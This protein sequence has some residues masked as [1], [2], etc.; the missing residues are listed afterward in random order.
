[1]SSV[2]SY[3]D[4]APTEEIREG[5]VAWRAY[6]WATVAVL[7]AVV[8]RGLLEPF[9]GAKSPA[10]TLFPAVA[11]VAWRF[12][13]GPSLFALVVGLV[14]VCF[15]F[16]EPRFSL[17]VE[18]PEY[19][20]SVVLFF[21][22]NL[23][24][25]GMFDALQRAKRQA[26]EEVV[27]RR[28][29]ERNLA[30]QE[31]LLRVTLASIGDAV[32]STDLH[33]KVSYMNSLAED[34]TGW[35]L[36]DVTNQT[37]DQVVRMV[38]EA[39]CV[40]IDNLAS[41]VLAE[42]SSVAARNH[43]LLISKDGNSIPISYVATPITRESGD[44]IG[45]ALVIR[46]VTAQRKAAHEKEQALATLNGLVASA[47]V[48][49]AILDSEMRYQ[50]VNGVLAKI[51]GRTLE[52][53]LG[54]KVADVIPALYP[55]AAA[56][57]ER[58][59]ET[60][61][62]IPEAILEGATATG[63]G[64]KRVFRE[65]WFPIARPENKVSAVGVIVQEITEQR[66]AEQELAAL[67]QRHTSL[68]DNAPLAVIEWD[69]DFQVTRWAGLAEKMFGWNAEEVLGR[70]IEEF[71]FVHADDELTVNETLAKLRDPTNK[72]VICHNRNNSK[73]GAIVDCEWYNSVV[74]DDSGK[75]I[76]VLSLVLDVTDRKRVEREL[77]RAEERFRASQEASLFGFTI[78]NSVRD[79]ADRIVDFQWEYV[80][81][82][83]ATI[84]RVSAADLVGQRLLEILPNNVMNS[85][86]F[87]RYVS[88]VE[89][90]L[91][92]DYEL[93][94]EGEGIDGWFRNMAVKLG[95]GVAV[96]F[97]DVTESRRHREQLT[98]SEARFRQLAE[99]MPQIVWVTNSQG[100]NIYVNR[101]WA[102]FTGRTNEEGLGRR[103]TASV[104]A[105]D[106]PGLQE[107]WDRCVA[108]GESYSAEYRLL[109]KEGSY[110]WQIVRGAPIKDAEGQLIR[111]YGSSTDIDD[112]K[113]MTDALRDADRKK[114]EFLATLSH[115][116]RNPLA[117]IRMG[118]ELLKMSEDDPSL[119]EETL[120][121]MERQTIQLITLVDDLLDL[122]RI[123][124]NK[125]ELQKCR[126]NLSDVIQSAV[127]ASWPGM[128]DAGHQF[129]VDL[130]SPPVF[131]DADPHRL[132]QVISN[133]L[134]NA[135]KYTPE[136][137]KIELS[138]ERRGKELLLIVKDNGIG[139]PPENHDRIFDMFAQIDRT[140]EKRYKGLGIGL[141]LVKSLV[142][143]HGGSVEVH[144]E[145]KN[146]GSEFHVR[147]PSVLEECGEESNQTKPDAKSESCGC[148]VLVVDDNRAA[149]LTLSQ[150]IKMLGCQVRTANDGQEGFD[151]AKEFLPDLV[152]MDIGMPKMNGYQ[153]AAA[154]R[155]Q[156]WG[157]KMTLVA[158][159]GWGQSEDKQRTKE[160]GF[161]HHLVKP[162]DPAQLRN[163][164][165]LVQQR[166][167]R[168]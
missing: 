46:D 82:V 11:F 4:F 147:L 79:D 66:R 97:A 8:A 166:E 164:L 98:E 29:A 108:K 119:R 125:L 27:A 152:L 60:N 117:P 16:I 144:S 58:V 71:G 32:V 21:L 142:R 57:F 127:E 114:D 96:S 89:S 161:D 81:P 63:P 120:A 86:L 160:A 17:M 34:L 2:D 23:A 87:D 132:A 74:H 77:R 1:M 10:L 9:L 106:L 113:C 22:V 129:S 56:L 116:L 148:R 49:I 70:S 78:L 40:A 7:I 104:H 118:L 141:S 88:V 47:P 124:G 103:W 64:V 143:M 85:D 20:A 151:L 24:S 6:G 72:F 15:L 68:V 3:S 139:I 73:T 31:S 48:G 145:G 90:G 146:R 99:A 126:V 130:P 94:Y 25:I 156:P 61:Q 135:A 137:G 162:A 76:A 123:T 19:R 131:L 67:V 55:Q 30:E 44:R 93:R 37:I 155:Q 69:A 91:P 112:Q 163:L 28:R 134:N 111:W 154:I 150:V 101:H 115:E 110:R 159:T 102:D 136:G 107:T 52:E 13:K 5:Q 168:Q 80:N 167:I 12:G 133:L 92:H 75:M 122:S 38:D 36:R 83:A 100:E 65:G 158:L 59:M 109:N 18:K 45:A 42:A 35:R 53:H 138:A 121:M 41:L 128:R 62:P 105:D 33:G 50:K 51:N 84:L 157:S 95:D 26:E 54:Q 14:A 39:S 43:T 153:A 149:A 165:N 140:I